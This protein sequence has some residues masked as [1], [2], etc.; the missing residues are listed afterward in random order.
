[1]TLML[2]SASI[3]RPCSSLDIVAVPGYNGCEKKRKPRGSCRPIE[4]KAEGATD[5]LGHVL[6]YSGSSV[7]TNRR[8]VSCT[9]SMFCGR[10]RAQGMMV[11][12]TMLFV[13]RTEA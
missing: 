11:T 10:V 9:G 1:M 7:A 5:T 2:L 8:A 12:K 4:A 13:G 3:T 6:H